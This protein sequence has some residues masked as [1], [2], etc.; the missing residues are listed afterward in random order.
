[1]NKGSK[2]ANN[3]LRD[4]DH[5]RDSKPTTQKAIQAKNSNKI[6]DIMTTFSAS[7][8]TNVDAQRIVCV[9]DS[10]I[11]KVMI[12]QYVDS[13]LFNNISDKGRSQEKEE[14]LTQLTNNSHLLVMREQDYETRL[15]PLLSGQDSILFT[16]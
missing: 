13:D 5:D 11:E 6:K 15:K 10:L 12:L 8:P 7:K 3:R 9:L 16:L 1:M 2:V 14:L 4:R